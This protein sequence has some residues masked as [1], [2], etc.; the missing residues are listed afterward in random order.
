[1]KA[2]ISPIKDGF[3]NFHSTKSTVWAVYGIEI[4]FDYYGFLPPYFL[5]DFINK[6]FGKCVF[7]QKKIE[8]RAP[9]LLK[10]VF[11]LCT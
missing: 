2:P 7:W 9:M 10:I 3:A 6:E 1:M 11:R 8:I 5:P 4:H